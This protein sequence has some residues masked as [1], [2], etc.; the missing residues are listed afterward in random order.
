MLLLLVLGGCGPER[1]IRQVGNWGPATVFEDGVAKSFYV[2]Q[3]SHYYG[4]RLWFDT[5]K[6]EHR[7]IMLEE[8]QT[9]PYERGGHASCGI[10]PRSGGA[11]RSL[12]RSRGGCWGLVPMFIVC[13]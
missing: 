10:Q 4:P 11:R 8:K 3:I 12:M 1:G 2:R 9:W 5:K 13:T 6:Y 7:A